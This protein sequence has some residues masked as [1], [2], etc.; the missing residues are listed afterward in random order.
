MNS[1]NNTQGVSKL[2]DQIRGRET[3]KDIYRGHS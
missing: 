2:H 3:E 1:M